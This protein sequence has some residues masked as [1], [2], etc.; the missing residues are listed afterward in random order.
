MK[1]KDVFRSILNTLKGNIWLKLFSLVI[2]VVIW[3]SVISQFNPTRSKTIENI[4]VSLTGIQTLRDKKLTTS[5]PTDVLDYTA[6]VTVDIPRD[7][8]SSLTASD[9]TVT[10]NLGDASS[11]GLQSIDLKAVTTKGTVANVTPSKITLSI[12][13]LVSVYVPLVF[14]ITGEVLDG[15]ICSQPASSPANINVSGPENL[16]KEIAEARISLDTSSLT[17]KYSASLPYGLY[18]AAGELVPQGNYTRSPAAV[19]VTMDVWKKKD[20]AVQPLVSMSE[21]LPDNY[22]ILQTKVSP[23]II[24]IAGYPEDIENI[25]Y[26]STS[27]INISG[28]TKDVVAVV[29]I[30]ATAGIKWMSSSTVTVT[31]RIGE[32]RETR[33]FFN[34]PVTIVSD[35]P[36]LNGTD[37]GQTVDLKITAAKSFFDNFNI[38]DFKL[39]LPLTGLSEGQHEVT[40]Q[41]IYSDDTE[42]LDNIEILPRK[43]NYTI[44]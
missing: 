14:E 36:E 21:Q 8:F 15:Y 38:K 11:D 24:T 25:E 13:N 33:S 40:V 18:N 42:G 1:V 35:D 30:T 16:V 31:V 44:G 10:A 23:D 20:I 37:S 26:I 9:I 2:A 4:P 12:D 41:Y 32:K 17:E 7:E 6:N 5:L 22:E 29:P 3:A 19:S 28:A 39:Y 34:L 43:I 27:A